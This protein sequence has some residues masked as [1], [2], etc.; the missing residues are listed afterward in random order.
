MN[1]TSAS[2]P[3]AVSCPSC[4]A[5]AAGAYCSACG[6][7]FLSESDSSLKHYFLHH[8]ATEV[9][10][11][12]G[13]LGLTLRTLVSAPGKLAA[14]YVRGRRQP[15]LNPLR[16]YLVVFIVQA[17]LSGIGTRILSFSD[18]VTEFDTTGWALKLIGQ[19]PKESN[20]L[21]HRIHFEQFTHW[22]SEV[23]TLLI[24][25]LVA[26]AQMLILRRYRRRYLEH[27]ALS[28]NVATFAFLLLVA[29]DV[30]TLIVGRGSINETMEVLRINCVGF[31]LPIYWLF[32]I[33]RFYG[34]S[35]GGAMLYALAVSIANI[36]IAT[37]LNLIE[38]ITLASIAKLS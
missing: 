33:R 12:D 25:F 32:A 3:A 15:Y 17:F 14:E 35:W 20:D 2:P 21:A 37:G 8:V 31:T 13:K 16:L 28:L 29:A 24:F 5:Q 27:L 7:K 30:V 23:G 11:W 10:D 34:T 6:E 26:A 38:L 22:F 4:G 36:L 9:L 19:M 18:R 1:D